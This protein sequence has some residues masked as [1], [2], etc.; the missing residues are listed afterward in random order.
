[1]YGRYGND[2]LNQ[3]LLIAACA[4]AL[5][6]IFLP[7]QARTIISF[8]TTAGIAFAIF[9]MFSR[10]T[11]ARRIELN[12]YL[13][14]ESRV[15]AWFSKRGRGFKERK[16]FKHFTC[17]QCMQK[18]RVPR[19]KGKIRITCTRCGHRFETKS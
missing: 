1:M 12:K 7:W 14:M 19:G 9:R 4:L 5:I 8:V 16:D 11:A 2:K 17:P 6:S 18:L 13:S 3:M 10:N 15:R